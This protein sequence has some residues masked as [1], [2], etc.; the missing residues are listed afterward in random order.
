MVSGLKKWFSIKSVKNK[1]ISI[2]KLIISGLL[3]VLIISGAVLGVMAGFAC[4][5]EIDG[6]EVAVA[7]N[8]K[9][10]KSV[11]KSLT[12]EQQNKYNGVRLTQKVDYR[13][14][15]FNRA[16]VVDRDDLKRILTDKLSFETGAAGIKVDGV[17]KLAVKDRG[18]AEQVLEDLK[19]A[20]R[21]DP[22]YTVEFG[23][24][25]EIEDMPVKAD[26]VLSVQQALKFL[27]GE[28]DTPD[29]YTVR[30]GDTLWNVA[31]ALD[32]NPEDLQ[33][34]N[35]GI[36]PEDIQIGDR[37]KVVGKTQPVVDI[38]ATAEKT[39]EEDTSFERQ[40]RNN[41]NLPY[42]QV[43]LIQNGENGLKRVKY[44][45]VAVNG[46]ETG[47]EVLEEEMI[48]KANPEI[49]ERGSQTLVASRGMAIPGGPV[50]SAYG[51]RW[52]RTHTGIDVAASNGEP[53]RAAQS[54]KVIRASWFG[55]Y[56][57]CVEIN[58]GNGLV[59]RY[60]HMSSIG[61]EV[62]QFVE[63]GQVIGRVGSTGISTG[64]HIHFETLV[65][66]VPKNPLT[67]SN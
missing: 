35:P 67:Y 66:G 53:V 23:Q 4:T 10:A 20:C 12:D 6:Q 16:G 43:R 48:K 9:T 57:N 19:Q 52:G 31:V 14:V 13:L 2:T 32:V 42:G 36:T 55:G 65:N 11:V 17:M 39:V 54:G 1:Q 56:G 33:A 50:T 58:H 29:Y 62:G 59:T 63:K 22:E 41:P 8:M 3:A 47:R 51:E 18:A 49:M 15:V 34:V 25:V 27:K 24:K 46:M 28:S 38:V 60:A 40:V 64:P 37:I 45:I 21:I 44:R 5:V 30:D 26:K 7:K 61:V